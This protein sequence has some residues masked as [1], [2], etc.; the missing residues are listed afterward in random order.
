ML[1]LNF[2][3]KNCFKMPNFLTRKLFKTLK[4]SKTTLIRD[5][6]VRVTGVSQHH[7]GV[8]WGPPWKPLTSQHYHIE[9]LKGALDWSPIMLKDV[10][11]SDS[12]KSHRC[13]FSRVAL[14]E[15][16]YRKW[17]VRSNSNCYFRELTYFETY[18]EKD[19]LIF[20]HRNYF[21][22]SGVNLRGYKLL[23]WMCLQKFFQW[24]PELKKLYLLFERLVSLGIIGDLRG[25]QA[26][27]D[28]AS[29][30]QVTSISQ[31]AMHLIDVVFPVWSERVF[32][33]SKTKLDKN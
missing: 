6:A 5:I 3:R 7:G 15:I 1:K 14:G 19:S 25:F 21:I 20:L 26:A 12:Y 18:F 11:L 9:G 13:C 30:H 22:W 8:N 23:D 32:R 24:I 2:S 28:S 10:S 29:W 27:F 31:T 4:L 17:L 16:S 33:G